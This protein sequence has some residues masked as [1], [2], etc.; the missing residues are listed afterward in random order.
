MV[1]IVLGVPAAGEAPGVFMR[2][3]A[4]TAGLGRR[5]AGDP[6]DCGKRLSKFSGARLTGN[7]KRA[8]CFGGDGNVAGDD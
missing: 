4:W 2:L 3:I 5:S 1:G 8:P 6:G 7:R